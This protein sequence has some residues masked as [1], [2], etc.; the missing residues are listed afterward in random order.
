MQGW[1]AGLC[2]LLA[3]KRL[4]RVCVRIACYYWWVPRIACVVLVEL[5]MLLGRAM[6]LTRVHTA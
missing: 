6:V 1:F 2:V 5:L 3:G 4:Q